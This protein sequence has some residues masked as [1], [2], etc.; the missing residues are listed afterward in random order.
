VPSRSGF[1][2]RDG[3]LMNFLVSIDN[4]PA[5]KGGDRPYVR[6][7]SEMPGDLIEGRHPPSAIKKER[8]IPDDR[9]QRPCANQH[10]GESDIV[11]VRTTPS[12]RI[13]KSGENLCLSESDI[14]N[15]RTTPE[16]RIPIQSEGHAFC[17][18][19]KVGTRTKMFDRIQPLRVNHS[20]CEKDME[21]ERSNYTDRILKSSAHQLFGDETNGLSGPFQIIE[22]H[23]LD[24][25]Q[26]GSAKTRVASGPLYPIEAGRA[27]RTMAG[28]RSHYFSESHID[29]A[30]P[31]TSR[32]P[33][34][35]R[36]NH[37][38]SENPLIRVNQISREVHFVSVD[39]AATSA[40]T[41]KRKPHIPRGPCLLRRSMEKRVNLKLSEDPIPPRGPDHR[42][43]SRSHECAKTSAKPLSL[44]RTTR[45]CGHS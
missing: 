11:A 10:G 19:D 41:D 30:D 12:D 7:L 26:S 37:L 34:N 35:Q 36:P 20:K 5:R 27:A 2:L 9:I 1:Q 22:S 29:G 18:S 8:S 42:R 21:R 45:D 38:S 33:T 6:K 44:A 23:C 24:E 14:S 40:P 31:S 4:N 16:D 43:L 15:G 25:I 28:K 39:P 17:D 3:G 32:A 13:H